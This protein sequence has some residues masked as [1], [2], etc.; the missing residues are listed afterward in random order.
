[1]SQPRRLSAR[2]CTKGRAGP[3]PFAPV[4]EKPQQH[5]TLQKR[6]LRPRSI[7]YALNE[8][9]TAVHGTARAKEEDARGLV[10]LTPAPN[11]DCHLSS[12]KAAPRK[13]PRRAKPGYWTWLQRVGHGGSRRRA[14]RKDARP[15]CL[16]PPRRITSS[17]H[18]GQRQRRAKG[19]AALNPH[20]PTVPCP[21]PAPSLARGREP[22]SNAPRLL[23]NPCF[24][25]GRG[26]R[27]PAVPGFC[28]SL[29]S[30]PCRA[31]GLFALSALCSL[32]ATRVR[33][34][35]SP[36]RALAPLLSSGGRAFAPSGSGPGGRGFGSLPSL[37][38]APGGPSAAPAAAGGWLSSFAVGF[39][40]SYV[41]FCF[42]AAPL[43][44]GAFRSLCPCAVGRFRPGCVVPAFAPG[45]FR[46]RGG[47]PVFV[48]SGGWPVFRF[49]G[50]PPRSLCPL[51]CGAP[52]SPCGWS[53]AVV[54]GF[55][56][57]GRAARSRWP[58]SRFP[59]AGRCFR[60]CRRP[61]GVVGW[62]PLPCFRLPP[63][64]WSG[65]PGGGACR[66]C[67]ARGCPGW[68]PRCWP[69]VGRL[70]W[71]AR[72][73]PMR[74]CVLPLPVPWC[75]RFPVPGG[76]PPLGSRRARS[77]WCARSRLAAPVPGWW[78]FLPRPVPLAC[79][80]P[81]LPPPAFA[82]W[83][84]V[85]GLPPR[86]L[87]VSRCRWWC[88][89]AGFPCCRPGAFGVRLALGSGL[90]VFC[91]ADIFLHKIYSNSFLF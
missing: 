63:R 36:L 71:V 9:A 1:M 66:R 4:L 8:S 15:S 68:S 73:V 72:R 65:F 53:F 7:I 48:A 47:G 56:S 55:G 42:R 2:P 24:C 25:R 91:C 16:S 27:T 19:R 79:P 69:P 31:G 85:R 80:L 83:V 30:R 13:K 34:L 58:G 39:W 32:R 74:L 57:G 67:S 45:V 35:R 38:P 26:P 18:S 22:F 81:R 70:W 11:N 17:I 12:P 20:A 87:R 10:P 75:F 82:G 46:L 23:K 33:S 29:R 49:V 21:A 59:C 64:R 61:P 50:S 52:G 41:R 43:V 86:W 89:P 51:L 78:S 90:A 84:P 3:A 76:G 37:S 62:S 6:R 28:C 5:S 54:G 14:A 40:G 88:F 60:G 44:R 77:P